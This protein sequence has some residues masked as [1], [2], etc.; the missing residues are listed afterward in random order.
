MD[1]KEDDP[2]ESFLSAES[3]C[4]AGDHASRKCLLANPSKAKRK[5]S[6]QH[7]SCQHHHPDDPALPP[8]KR[9]RLDVYVQRPLSTRLSD[10]EHSDQKVDSE[11]Q[12]TN[13]TQETNEAEDAVKAI[14]QPAACFFDTDKKDLTREDLEKERAAQVTKWPSIH[15]TLRSVKRLTWSP[16]LISRICARVSLKLV[17]QCDRC[18]AHDQ[19][20]RT[21]KAK[22]WRREHPPPAEEH[23]LRHIEQN[24]PAW[25]SARGGSSGASS[26]YFFALV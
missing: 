7:F 6:S 2:I 23:A 20:Q 14:C 13:E 5:R 12:D 26:L 24:T 1:E 17:R 8:K 22:E 9:A 16:E 3:T 19:K 11:I 15:R 25:A 10:D 4:N 21:P 18:H